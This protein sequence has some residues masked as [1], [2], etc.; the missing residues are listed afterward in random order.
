MYQLHNI[1]DIRSFLQSQIPD[2]LEIPAP[3]GH[4]AYSSNGDVMEEQL[5][6]LIQSSSGVSVQF[7]KDTNSIT[8][9][10]NELVT[11]TIKR[12]FTRRAAQV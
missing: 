2:A 3:I 12:T 10:N 8:E 9:I 11:R 4:V 5:S 1:E 6:D 7:T